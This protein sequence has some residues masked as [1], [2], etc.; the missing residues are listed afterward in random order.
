M[1]KSLISAVTAMIVSLA[2]A[3][4]PASTQQKAVSHQIEKA[5][6]VNATTH[7][8]GKQ[9]A[10]VEKAE[11]PQPKS[12]SILRPSVTDR[13]PPAGR[14]DRTTLCRAPQGARHAYGLPDLTALQTRRAGARSAKAATID[15]NG[16]I[17]A[18]PADG[19]RK[20]YQRSSQGQNFYYYEDEF[21]YGVQSGY[22]EV[23]EDGD[24][25]YIKNPITRYTVG[26]Y[27]KGTREGNT[28]TVPAYQPLYWN[29]DW[30]TT[31]SLRWVEVTA[32]GQF[33]NADDHA[34]S[35]TFTIEG[36]VI[37]LTDPSVI[38]DGTQSTYI[39]ASVWD[40]DDTITGYGDAGSVLTYAPDFE[41]FGTDPVE[42]PE[43]A[44]V[45]TWYLNCT[46]ENMDDYKVV[47]NR[48][49]ETAFVGND[50]YVRGLFEYFPESWVKGAI[51]GDVIT[52]EAYQFLGNYEVYETWLAGGD[53][54]EDEIEP[55]VTASYDAESRTITFDTYLLANASREE[56]NWLE[57]DEETVL[58]AE[59]APDPI[60][61]ELTAELPYT[62][63]F[64]TY[65]EQQQAAIWDNNYDWCTFIFDTDYTVHS[66]VAKYVYSDDNDADDFLVFPGLSLEAGKPYQVRVD[67][68]AYNNYYTESLEIMVATDP[69]ASEFVAI[70]PE[71]FV[72]ADYETL[73]VDFIPETDGIYYFAIH[74]TS[75]ASQYF[76]LV[77]NF[78]VKLHDPSTPDVISVLTV[79]PDPTAALRATVT[80]VAPELN[81][82][83]NA[84]EGEVTV[85]VN[86][87]G[88][89]V[90]SA[91]V[92]PGA[93]VTFVDETIE[94]AGIVT[95]EA[96]A[97]LGDYES[98]PVSIEAYIGED[99]PDSPTGFTVADL[100][101]KVGLSWD[102][103]TVGQQGGIVLPENVT[104]DLC[105]VKSVTYYGVPFY[106][107]DDTNPYA[108]DIA[109]TSYDL[110]YPT[111]EG[112]QGYTYF[113]L[114]ARNAIGHSTGVMAATVTGA[115][116]ELPVVETLGGDGATLDYWWGS[117]SDEAT[118]EAYGG[119]STTSDAEFLFD[120]PAAGWIDLQSGK[121]SLAGAIHPTLAFDYE[122]PC[123]FELTVF[124]PTRSIAA[125]LTAGTDYTLSQVDLSELAEE[126]W[127]RFTLHALF[128]EAGKGYV[129]NVKFV[130]L[131]DHNVKVL[132]SAPESLTAGQSAD[133]MVTVRNEAENP[134]SGYAVKVYAGDEVIAEYPAD[135]TVE[136]APYTEVSYS[137]VLATTVFDPAEEVTLRA[138]AIY[139]ADEKP[140][141]NVAETI[142]SVL[143]P[144]VAPV[145]EVMAVRDEEGVTLTWTSPSDG[146]SE[147]TE[148]FESYPSN[149]VY[150]D[151]QYCGEWGAI[152]R[153]KGY[154][155][156]W[157]SGFWD[158]M[159]E[160]YAFGII[161]VAEE[162]FQDNFPAVSGTKTVIFMSEIDASGK[163]QK[164]DKYLVSPELPGIA[165]TIRFNVN[166]ITDNYGAEL[167]E[168]VASSTDASAESFSVVAEY[169]LSEKGW[170]EYSVDLPA[171]TRYFA[172]HYVTE[173]AFGIFVDDISYTTADALPTGYNV[174]L[175]QTLVATTPAD[176]TSY[177]LAGVAS[178]GEHTASVTA[179]YGN[180][181]SLPVTVTLSPV[182][183]ISEL[184]LD[185]PVEVY[186]T[187]G[188]RVTD[189]Q[190]LKSGI[191]VAGGHKVIVK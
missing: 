17:L 148:D 179:L 188:L 167:F 53:P 102:A 48:E 142:L 35:F 111:N 125:T 71:T 77:D 70:L 177:L 183:G 159:K 119:L 140:A 97:A 116:Y 145:E 8:L 9:K 182:T 94:A 187:T 86:R 74:A 29:A 73:S 163:D 26:S 54:Y 58:S 13:V 112:A 122:G 81:I 83:G 67:A 65:A 75:E 57:Y 120:A 69:R 181:E 170:H 66:K 38:W 24:D 20:Y 176:V 14:L 99:A 50:F 44:D 105:P 178:E 39:M 52:F 135:Q 115:P 4:I 55:V 21:W 147:K 150:T 80:C 121:V 49:V 91:T 129:R 96:T 42:L 45:Q 155:Y 113:G 184:T 114:I 189:S 76:L 85:R 174:Y 60:I 103:V 139:E 18:P 138:E 160:V 56:V 101:D 28:I 12:S 5:Q 84:I 117:D 134:A 149:S 87:D 31:I 27:V 62:N 89:T 79:T 59:P 15:E 127:V 173:E 158:H 166:I 137:T 95:Y 78:Q 37:T 168:V 16:I 123:A 100:D 36:D 7:Q 6:S 93:T 165:Q 22:V 64:E 88:A 154:T 133:V 180:A 132:V 104:Y 161:D 82:G 126:P 47:F 128:S 98:E 171:G 41:G 110:E 172:I 143:A 108:T 46:M 92:A 25:V 1:K 136:L 185:Q 34:D 68:R 33:E 61:T 10:L 72:G 186:T 90:Y 191:Y 43:G 162:G 152:D 51:D 106:Y 118:S 156:S 175:D 144:A 32:D 190:G 107:V 109:T 23:V 146:A 151:G 30:E 124:G 164:S 169:A 19:V 131:M 153:S 40:D 2:V 130:D 157:N 11:A 141:D 63:T 3:Q